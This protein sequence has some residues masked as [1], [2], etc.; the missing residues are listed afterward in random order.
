MNG[1][2]YLEMVSDI[3][4]SNLYSQDVIES[5]FFERAE[6]LL[7]FVMEEHSPQLVDSL[8]NSMLIHHVCTIDS[9]GKLMYSIPKDC[10]DIISVEHLPRTHEFVLLEIEED[11]SNVFFVTFRENTWFVASVNKRDYFSLLKPIQLSTLFSKLGEQIERVSES[12]KIF[13]QIRYLV[14]QDERGIIAATENVRKIQR[15]SSD[16]FLASNLMNEKIASRTYTYEEKK[17]LEIIRP[18]YLEEQSVLIRLGIS[19]DRIEALKRNRNLLFI[20][21]SLIHI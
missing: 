14:I 4:Q 20:M 6:M 21:L 18:F 8:R 13:P 1:R 5:L 16:E 7:H 2:L 17:V 10:T 3:I 9:R 19:M 11:P 15:I 12:V